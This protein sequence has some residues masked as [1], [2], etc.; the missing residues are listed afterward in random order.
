[1][2]AKDTWVLFKDDS[3]FDKKQIPNLGINSYFQVI[4]KTEQDVILFTKYDLGI[5][6]PYYKLNISSLTLGKCKSSICNASLIEWNDNYL[7][8][9]TSFYPNLFLYGP[10]PLSNITDAITK[11]TT[12]SKVTTKLTTKIKVTTPIKSG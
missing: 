3:S 9:W 5:A 4:K 7:G 6:L 10:A 12:K 11:A 8:T 1:M 2:L